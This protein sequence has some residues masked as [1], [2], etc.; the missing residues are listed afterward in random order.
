MM[1]FELII[2]KSNQSLGVTFG[3]P[4]RAIKSQEKT[5]N[6]KASGDDL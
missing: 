4:N 3:A 5:L 2:S 6:S 1:I